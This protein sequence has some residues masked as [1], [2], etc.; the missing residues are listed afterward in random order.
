MAEAT[1]PAAPALTASQQSKAAGNKAFVAKKYE[2]A[3]KL[4]S[5]A[6]EQADEAE[7]AK[8]LLYA[9]LAAAHLASGKLDPAI[10]NCDACLAL[11][12]SFAKAHLRKANALLKQGKLELAMAAVATGM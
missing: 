3:A 11:E 8:H 5:Q 10:A 6:I 4:Y 9:N 2:E 12:P 1:P 7:P